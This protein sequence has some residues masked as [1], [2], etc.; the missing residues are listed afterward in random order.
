MVNGNRNGGYDLGMWNCR[1]GLIDANYEATVKFDEVKQFILKRKLHM[2]C[3]I[4]TDLHSSLSRHKR[5]V[6]FTRSEICNILGIPG[7]NIH[8]PATWKYYGQA[9]LIVY[10]KE[11]LKVNER[12]LEARLT[13]LPMI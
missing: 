9:R 7:Y 13:D 4:E 5:R 11:E 2:L 8:L 10:V 3:L 12:L 6:T 1:R